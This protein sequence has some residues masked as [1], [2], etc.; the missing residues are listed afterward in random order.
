MIKYLSNSP[1]DT[2]IFAEKIAKKLSYPKTILLFGDMGSGKTTF[3][4]SLIKFLGVDSKITSPTF[5]IVNQ[6]SVLDKTINHFDMYRLE[7]ESEAEEIGV[8][9]MIRD[10]DSINIIEWPQKIA[11]LIFGDVIKIY[12]KQIDENKREFLVEGLK[13]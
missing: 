10:K 1:K 9:E 7:D 5:N 12:I 2:D 11:S 3:T 13:W 6:Y 8:S 4:K